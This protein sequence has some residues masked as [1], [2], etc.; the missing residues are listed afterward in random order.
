MASMHF[1]HSLTIR[2]AHSV[3]EQLAADNHA[4]EQAVDLNLDDLVLGSKVGEGSFGEVF[5]AEY[6]CQMCVKMLK[7]SWVQLGELRDLQ[8]EIHFL[9]RV[10]HPNLV[11]FY[12]AGTHMQQG[13]A[14]PFVLLEYASHGSLQRLL[15]SVNGQ[16]GTLSPEIRLSLVRNISQGMAYLH[17]LGRDVM[18]RDL[19]SANV[20]VFEDTTST[21]IAK[22]AD[23][24]SARFKSLQAPTSLQRRYQRIND[25]RGGVV[26]TMSSLAH[27]DQSGGSATMTLG[28]GTPLYKSP[29]VLRNDSAYT[30]AAD[31]FSFGVVMWEVM[32][33]RAPDLVS[34]ASQGRDV[35]G[36]YEEELL[37]L[38]MEGR[39]LMLTPAE[40]PAWYREL[41]AKC[42]AL[43]PALRISFEAVNTH[44][45]SAKGTLNT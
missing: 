32:A 35:R 36:S 41:M 27:P 21:L 25:A 31:V 20:L 5:R 28:L 4:L 12:G 33:Q 17:S 16:P 26:E 43:D 2:Y 19:K 1:C 45:A 9:K 18:H 6:R 39:R 37:R 29:E 22:V 8:R 24:G 3:L 15:Y 14:T 7:T 40:A 11:R 30:Q 34:E 38:L 23:L 13:M 10:H 42:F 44:F